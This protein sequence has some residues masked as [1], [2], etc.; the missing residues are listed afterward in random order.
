MEI[1]EWYREYSIVMDTCSQSIQ[2]IREIFKSDVE[3]YITDE[4][5][6]FMKDDFNFPLKNESEWALESREW[7][8]KPGFKYTVD[9]I[10]YEVIKADNIIPTFDN[11]LKQPICK[12]IE[13]RNLL[14]NNLETI[15]YPFEKYKFNNIIN[16]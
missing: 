14:I 9:G 3:K 4:D 16:F 6:D 13:V 11:N 10:N 7:I 2:R 8:F 15:E 5:W 1:A 12:S